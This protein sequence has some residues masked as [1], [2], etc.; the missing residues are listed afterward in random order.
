MKSM[1][2]IKRAQRG[3]T[4]IEL[5]IVVAI[6]GIL[7]AVAIPQYQ[8]YTM[9]AKLS[10]VAAGVGPIE[11]AMSEFF[12]TNGSFP[13]TNALTAAG[14]KLIATKEATYTITSGPTATTGEITATFNDVLGTNVPKNATI[15]FSSTPNQGD[16]AIK[17]E[18][19]ASA[20]ITN[21]AALNYI[22]TKLSGS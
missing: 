9:R 13:D 11:L 6:I 14:I 12:Q 4:L 3:F 15:K 10:N 19:K 20:D 1:K 16:T 8:D 7:A 22:K 5:M 2:M 17:W 21:N 18:A